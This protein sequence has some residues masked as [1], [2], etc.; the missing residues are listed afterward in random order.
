MEREKEIKNKEKEQIKDELTKI[1]K[2]MTIN[3]LTLQRISQKL[4]LIAM[5]KSHIKTEDEYIDNLKEQIKETGINEKEQQK[6]LDELKKENKETMEYLKL[7]KEDFS[8]LDENQFQDKL[9]SIHNK[10]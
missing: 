1:T 8:N 6:K 10:K 9:K 2:E 4:E 5:N 7:S 3:I